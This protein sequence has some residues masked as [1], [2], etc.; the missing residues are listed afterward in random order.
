MKIMDDHLS[1]SRRDLL[2][3]IGNIGMGNA[4]TS[5][6][7]LLNHKKV[8]MN[9]PEVSVV[10]VGELPDHMGGAERMV[11]GTFVVVRE[12]L[13]MYLVFILPLEDARQIAGVLTEGQTTELDELGFSAVLEV[14]NIV[15][16]GYLNALAALINR[17]LIPSPPGMAVDLTEAILGTILAQIELTEDSVILIKTSFFVGQAKI[18]GYLSLIPAND[19]FELLYE[20]MMKGD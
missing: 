15:T 18:D 20:I 2:K 17:S 4:A 3:E 1:E 8:M 7:Q 13:P 16:S 14:G 11:T 19:S 6:S 10:A 9:L 5:L 12:E